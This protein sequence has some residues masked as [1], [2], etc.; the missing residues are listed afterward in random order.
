MAWAESK[1]V[2]GKMSARRWLHIACFAGALLAVALAPGFAQ[3]PADETAAGGSAAQGRA[4]FASICHTCHSAQK[5]VNRIGPSLYG[6]VG[7]K[8]ASISDYPYSDVMRHSGFVWTPQQIFVYI[9]N[10]QQ[11]LPGV[12]MHY[13]GLTRA[14]DRRDVIAYLETLH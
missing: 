13:A 12:K 8:A 7:R 1:A 3:A 2:G 6:V 5:G 9:A 11:V 14:R 10:P 4:I